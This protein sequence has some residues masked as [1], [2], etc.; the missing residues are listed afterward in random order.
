MENN[1]IHIRNRY[2]MQQRLQ[3]VYRKE[4]SI[5]IQEISRQ[6]DKPEKSSGVLKCASLA[7]HSRFSVEDV[8]FKAA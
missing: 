3:Y 2:K 4:P 1:F 8:Q 7:I 6:N 5:E